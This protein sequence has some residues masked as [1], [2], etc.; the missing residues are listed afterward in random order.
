MNYKQ[1]LNDIRWKEKSRQVKE[2]DNFVC[3][4]CGANSKTLPKDS[5]LNVHHIR[6]LK[7]TLLWDY[8]NEYL[9][10][11]CKA[12]HLNEHVDLHVLDSTIEEMLTSGLFARDV[13]NK[14]NV[15][16]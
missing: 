14:F 13:L 3:Q 8:P 7:N 5:N 6:Y 1:Q 11:L 10:T 4:K 16:L 12:C 15:K 2:R 9:I